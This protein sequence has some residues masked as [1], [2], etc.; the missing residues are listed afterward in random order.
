MLER[1]RARFRDE[2]GFTITELMVALTIL[3]VAFFA[4]AGS[5]SIGLRIVAEGR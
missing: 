3:S 4:L 1:V 2:S 5:A